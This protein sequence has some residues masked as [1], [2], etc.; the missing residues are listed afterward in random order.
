MKPSVIGHGNRP[1]YSLKKI[2]GLW[3]S[4]SLMGHLI[5][6][7]GIMKVFVRPITLNR[8]DNMS[9]EQT[10]KAYEA[11]SDA[12]FELMESDYSFGCLIYEHLLSHRDQWK[13][14]EFGWSEYPYESAFECLWKW[15]CEGMSH[16][17]RDCVNRYILKEQ[18]HGK[19]S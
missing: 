8:G 4:D 15:D 2:W 10:T 9:C 7:S 16:D 5:W 13:E 19:I 1:T 18:I 11:A 14:K 3:V 17:I 6:L 12:F